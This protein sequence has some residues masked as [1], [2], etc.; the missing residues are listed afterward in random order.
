MPD[1]AGSSEHRARTRR[2]KTNSHR[3]R[4]AH[5][6]YV[7]VRRPGFL[8]NLYSLTK[9]QQAIREWAGVMNDRTGNLPPLPDIFPDYT[10]PIVPNQPDGLKLAMPRLGMP[11][12]VLSLNVTKSAPAA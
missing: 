8:C 6:K 12:P 5:A 9:G 11:T 3:C 4:C 10:A 7:A 1:L 2:P